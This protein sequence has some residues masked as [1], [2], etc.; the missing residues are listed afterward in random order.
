MGVCW[1][2]LTSSAWRM[3]ATRPSIMSEGATMSAPA[4]AG[5]GLG[6]QL[7]RRVVG[8]LAVFDLAAVAVTGVLAE[9][10]VGDD[11]QP[12]DFLLHCLHRALDDAVLGVGARRDFV[13]RFGDAEEDDGGKAQALD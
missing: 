5:L 7:E 13:F 12:G 6:Q 8:D 10:N 11:Q 3:A 4:R 9:T 1:K 2:P